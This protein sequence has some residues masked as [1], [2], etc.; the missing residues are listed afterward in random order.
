MGWK[1]RWIQRPRALGCVCQRRVFA[2]HPH[3]LLVS[4][5]TWESGGSSQGYCGQARRTELVNN[6]AEETRKCEGEVEQ[7]RSGLQGPTG[8]AVRSELHIRE[9]QS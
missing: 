8:V 2:C 5:G 4:G 3:S 6:E 1:S 7:F 9:K